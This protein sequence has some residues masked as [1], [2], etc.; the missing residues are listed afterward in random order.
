LN[1]LP[2]QARGAVPIV[3]AAAQ[4]FASL[5]PIISRNIGHVIMWSITCI[6]HERQKQTS[7]A[8]ENEVRQ[9]LAD[10]LLVMAKDLMVFSGMVKYKLPP[11][12]YETLA[13]AGAEI[14]AY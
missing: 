4:S 6:G 13:R 2:L 14:G 11:R 7:G 5:P 9:G 8:Y 12:V 3:R 1:I 10:T